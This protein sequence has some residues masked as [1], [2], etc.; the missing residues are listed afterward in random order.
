MF[1]VVDSV[2]Y[3]IPSSLAIALI[4]DNAVQ[5]TYGFKK[6]PA[7]I[8]SLLSLLHNAAKHVK[9][10]PSVAED[11]GTPERT[12]QHFLQRVL[13]SMC[14]RQE[15]SA[16]QAV[17]ALLGIKAEFHTHKKTVVF[18]ESYAPYRAPLFLAG[19]VVLFKT[20]NNMAD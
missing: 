3:N 10:N 8:N 5:L 2:C 20:K 14:G 1:I 17:A 18:L 15:Y 16:N 11:S 12:T 4:A 19:R 9:K 7:E 13:N 6:D